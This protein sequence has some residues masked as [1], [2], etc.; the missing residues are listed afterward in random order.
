WLLRWAGHD[1]VAVLDGGFAAWQAAEHPVTTDPVTPSRGDI[2]VRSGSMPV[3]DAAGAAEVARAG[4]LLDARSAERYSGA[5]EPVDPR[6]GHVPGAVNAPFAAQTDAAGKWH[7][8]ARLAER[9]TELGV[10]SQTPVA[11]YCG[12]GITASSVVLALRLAGHPEPAALYAGSWS[13][14]CSDP[15]RPVATGRQP[16]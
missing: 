4:V 14:W 8:P 15:Q 1:A 13:D 16:G 9:F 10:T 5:N 6:A 3:L 11:A 12:S 2:V 7:D